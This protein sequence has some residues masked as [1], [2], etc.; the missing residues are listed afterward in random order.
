MHSLVARVIDMV[1]TEPLLGRHSNDDGSSSSSSGRARGGSGAAAPPAPAATSSRQASSTRQP[2]SLGPNLQ[3]TRRFQALMALLRPYP[4]LALSLLAIAEALVVAEGAPALP[5]H[6]TPGF[7]ARALPP[8][9]PFVLPSVL[10][11]L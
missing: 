9:L 4:A 5:P 7:A 2:A 6:P 1:V 10:P 11:P 3:F 8:V